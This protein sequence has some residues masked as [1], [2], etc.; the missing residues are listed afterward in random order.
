MSDLH[1]TYNKTCPF[2]G[3]VGVLRK[4]NRLRRIFAYVFTPYDYF[5]IMTTF[6]FHNM[7]KNDFY[8]ACFVQ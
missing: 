5:V 8:L 1:V 4:N 7:L 3:F 6:F 2:Q